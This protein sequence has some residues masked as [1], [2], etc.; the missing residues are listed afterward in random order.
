M[1]GVGQAAGDA[2]ALEHESLTRSQ[3]MVR[4]PA[5][6]VAPDLQFWPCAFTGNAKRALL[7]GL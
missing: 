3:K 1:A 7:W 5:G 6:R 2:V 4:S